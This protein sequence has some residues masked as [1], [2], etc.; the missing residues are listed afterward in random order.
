MKIRLIILNVTILT[1]H[2]LR[3]FSFTEYFK[4]K[5]CEQGTLTQAE[6]CI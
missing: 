4:C 6:W 2:L 1:K 5:P 3:Q